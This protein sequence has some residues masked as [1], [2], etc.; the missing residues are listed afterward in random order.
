M[1]RT[2][3]SEGLQGEIAT[4]IQT[5]LA[6]MKRVVG[7]PNKFVDGIFGGKTVKALQQMQSAASLPSTGAVDDETWKQL[8]PNPIPSIFERCLGLTVFF[9]GSGYGGIEGNF[10]GQGMTW[11]LVGFTLYEGEIQRILTEAEAAAPGTLVGAMGAQLAAEWGVQTAKPIGQQ[12]AWANSISTGSQKD[13]L[14]PEWVQAFARLGA[15]PAIQLLQKQHALKDYY[16]PCI[17][18]AGQLSLNTELGIALCFDAHVQNGPSRLKAVAQLVQAGYAC[19]QFA[20]RMAF[21]EALSSYSVQSSQADVLL[22]KSTIAKG[23]GQ[24]RGFNLQLTSW[25]LDEVP[26]P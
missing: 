22:R 21:A 25:G 10:D 18:T 9:E 16:T 19:T 3:F 26:A 24:A 15:V 7:D 1:S 11:G 2:W 23:G 14:P 8:T 6:G 17:T 20:Q 13:G 5:S 4:G 12:V